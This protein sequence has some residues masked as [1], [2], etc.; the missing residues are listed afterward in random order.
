MEFKNFHFPQINSITPQDGV[1]K[2]RIESGRTGTIPAS[3]AKSYE[4]GRIDAFK[5]NWKKGDPDQPHFFWDSDV[6]K[7][8]EGIANSLSLHPDKELEAEYDKIIDLIA[9]AQQPDGYLN[10]YFTVVEPEQRWKKISETH[11]LYCAGHLLEAAVAGYTLLGK[12]KFLDVMC[13]YID[14]IDTVFGAEEGKL[15]G[16]PGHQELELALIRLYEVTGNKKY[17][18]LSK[19]FI[20]ERGKEPHF[21]RDVQKHEPVYGLIEVQ[22]HKPV[23]EETKAVGHSVR[24]VYMYSA[25][26]DQARIYNDEEL[27]NVCEKIYRNITGK[28]MYITGGIGSTFHGEAFTTDYDLSNGTSMYAESC[29]AIGLVRFAGR[30][31]NITGDGKY[32]DTVERAIFN[33]ILSGI[34]LDGKKYFYTNYLEMDENYFPY[35]MGAS[36]RQPWFWCSC[37]PTNFCRFLPEMLQYCW[38]ESDDEVTLNI[39]A[40]T[41]FKSRFGEISVQSLYPYDG[42]VSVT[43][44]ADGKFKLSCRIPNWCKGATFLLNGEKQEI[45]AQNGFVTFDREWKKGDKIE[46]M[47]PMP[48]EVMRSNSKVTGNNGRIALMRGPLVY[49][50]ET[51]DNPQGVANMIIPAEQEFKLAEAAGLPAGTVAITG[52][53][54]YENKSEELYSSEPPT[55]TNGKFTAIP[56]ALWQNRGKANMAV[57]IREK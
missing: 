50:C 7:V 55:M 42:A 48:V 27:F 15:R 46:Y 45:G 21:Y 2:D 22:S 56:Y 53:A 1:L 43:V 14:Y 40:A 24:A 19:F 17:A 32:V 37:C 8:L 44:N 39:P 16:Y 57:W 25:M 49:A 31:F 38:S 47:L 18:D 3:L 29:A 28:R 4:T 12:R 10:V 20:D 30:M 52:S 13:R 36:E 51:V 34:S 9:S 54:L 41:T 23:R 35:N 5:L 26:A 33:G 11:E 6:A